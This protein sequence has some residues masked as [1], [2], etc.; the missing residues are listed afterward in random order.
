MYQSSLSPKSKRLSLEQHHDMSYRDS[1]FVLTLPFD[2]DLVQRYITDAV[3]HR[4]KRRWEWFAEAQTLNPALGTL[5]Y[6][7]AEVRRMIWKEMFWCRETLSSDGLWEY[8][9]T[10]GTIFDT[11]AYYFGFG[12]RGLP[13]YNRLKELRLVSTAVQAESDDVFLTFR[14]FRFN[15][16][17]N[18]SAFLKQLTP[19]ISARI[20]SVDVGICPVCKYPFSISL[21]WSQSSL[22]NLSQLLHIFNF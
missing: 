21:G 4:T 13:S 11:S 19:V 10:L 6:L 7:P 5:R 2:Q 20:F 14:T 3:L 17:Q 15:H 16:A 18:L 8:D 22:P 12:R 1:T 9:C